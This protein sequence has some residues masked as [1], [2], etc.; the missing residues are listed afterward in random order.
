[1][2]KEFRPGQ[3]VELQMKEGKGSKKGIGQGQR[4]ELQVKEGKVK[5]EIGQG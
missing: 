4:V 1:M 5:R 3:C 2:K